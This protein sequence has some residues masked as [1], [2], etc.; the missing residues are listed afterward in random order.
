[1]PDADHELNF[2]P[3]GQDVEIKLDSIL[4][5][6]SVLAGVTAFLERTEPLS[7]S[8]ND[9]WYYMQRVSN[10]LWYR[11]SAQPFISFNGLLAEGRFPENGSQND[12]V[13]NYRPLYF[14]NVPPGTYHLRFVSNLENKWGS[15]VN[16]DLK[17][18]IQILNKPNARKEIRIPATVFSKK[19]E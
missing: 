12:A 17:P 5:D 1:M 10:I 18:D 7:T 4:P 6:A 2:S 13:Y 11:P 8:F 14:P 16:T 15:M 3:Q 9:P 19:R